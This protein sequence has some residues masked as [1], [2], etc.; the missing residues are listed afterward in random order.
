MA[1]TRVKRKIKKVSLSRGREVGQEQAQGVN[2]KLEFKQ[3]VFFG[4]NPAQ[5]RNFLA[6]TRLNKFGQLIDA[7]F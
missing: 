4:Q 2:E 3:A 7:S 5:D 1:R 6:E